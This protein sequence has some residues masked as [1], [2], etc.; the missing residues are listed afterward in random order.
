MES[1]KAIVDSLNIP[2][3]KKA[4]N[5]RNAIIL[6]I[7]YS[8]SQLALNNMVARYAYNLDTISYGNDDRIVCF[9]RRFTSRIS[10]CLKAGVNVN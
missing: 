1:L 2:E 8:M 3:K 7:K 4:F 5:K 9:S 10:Y 6:N